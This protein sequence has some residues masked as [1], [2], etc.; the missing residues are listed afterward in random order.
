MEVFRMKEQKGKKIYE[1]PVWQKEEL[2]AQFQ[3]TCGKRAS[4]CAPGSNKS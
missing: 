1:K 3:T 4:N 2:F